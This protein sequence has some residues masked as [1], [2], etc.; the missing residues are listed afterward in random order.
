[1]NLISLFIFIFIIIGLATLILLLP[2]IINAKGYKKRK[3]QTFESCVAS[4]GIAT[5]RYNIKFQ[6]VAVLFL[7]I[8][9]YLILIMPWI[10]LNNGNEVTDIILFQFLFPVIVLIIAYIFA[11]FSGA[12]NWED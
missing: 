11:I 5:K 10:L 9:A 3:I 7:L 12:L 4:P 6:K 2:W 1:M 8:K